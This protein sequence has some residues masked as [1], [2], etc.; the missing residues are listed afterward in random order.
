[1]SSSGP[2]THKAAGQAKG[3]TETESQSD[4][5]ATGHTDQRGPRCGAKRWLPFPPPMAKESDRQEHKTW[6]G[7][8]NR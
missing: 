6:D 7:F 3:P 5:Q 4:A 1:M 2:Q 8:S